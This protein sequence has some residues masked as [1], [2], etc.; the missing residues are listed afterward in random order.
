MSVKIE[1]YLD[2]ILG[3]RNWDNILL[4]YTVR[5]DLFQLDFDPEIIA[6]YLHKLDDNHLIEFRKRIFKLARDFYFEILLLESLGP[7]PILVDDIEKNQSLNYS[8]RCKLVQHCLEFFKYLTDFSNDKDFFL[9]SKCVSF[10]TKKVNFPL[11]K[12]F[13]EKQINGWKNLKSK[14]INL[15]SE[16]NNFKSLT[17]ECGQKETSLLISNR[18]IIKLKEQNDTLKIILTF[19]LILVISLFI[20][21]IFLIC[22]IKI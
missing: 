4:R 18:K 6:K 21:Y 8:I 16:M 22:S 10:S 3:T 15:S 13:L 19:F 1:H 2:R 17:S 20:L 5:E 14:V 7:K 9:P 12:S 11:G